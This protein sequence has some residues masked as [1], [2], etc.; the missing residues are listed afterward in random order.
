MAHSKGV[1]VLVDGAHAIAH[2]DFNMKELGCD[3]YGASLHKWLSTPLGAGLLY[4]NKPKIKNLIPTI[5]T[6][7]D[8]PEDIKKLN[9]TGTH[10]VYT[11]LTIKDAID[12]YFKIGK[13]RKEQRLR[14]LQRY[15]T[16]QVRNINGIILNTPEDPTRSCGIANVGVIKMK[17]SDM[18]KTL[19]EKY[20]IYTVAIDGQG[21]HGCR[22]TPNIYTSLSELDQFV[23]ALKEMA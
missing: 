17:P 5:A 22:I 3:Y 23:K 18:A 12:F 20:K 11:D 10:P 21:V 7:T 19:L 6:W 1:D 2:I 4:I 9:H 13:E 15:W 14:Y 16:D 8:N